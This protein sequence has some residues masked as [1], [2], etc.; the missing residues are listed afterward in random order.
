LEREP[1]AAARADPPPGSDPLRAH[2]SEEEEV[3]L[4]IEPGV[5]EPVI[6]EPRVKVSGRRPAS[7]GR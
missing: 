7:P 6:V 1:I 4:A 2:V 3:P 5:V